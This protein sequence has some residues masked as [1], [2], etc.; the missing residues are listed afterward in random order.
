MHSIE[1]ISLI[2]GIISVIAAVFGYLISQGLKEYRY[3]K[4]RVA[5]FASIISIVSISFSLFY[6]Q[7]K[8]KLPNQTDIQTQLARLDNVQKSLS[9]L[10]KFLSEQ[11]SR[12]KDTETTIQ[13]LEN[14][15][16]TLK[17]IVEADRKTVEAF[18]ILF[19]ERQLKSVWKERIYSFS[20]GIISS[21]LA[22]IIIRLINSKIKSRKP[23]ITAKPGQVKDKPTIYFYDNFETFEGWQDYRKGTISHSNDFSF[24]GNNSLKKHGNNDPNGGYK[25]FPEPISFNFCFSGWI[26][27]PSGKPGGKADRLAVEDENFNGYGFCVAHGSNF[28]QI[29]RR[30]NGKPS[31]TNRGNDFSCPEDQW[32]QFLYYIKSNGILELQI[33]NSDGQSLI[34]LSAQDNKFVTFDRIVIH[35]GQPY[36]VD[37]LKVEAIES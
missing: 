4:W 11:R 32:Y 37:E 8:T 34:S 15:R 35:G 2:L 1:I 10:N 29:E 22:A 25:I 9:D 7:N 13:N 14:E 26:Y 3:K 24:N 33:L 28:L 17:P 5:I 19:E 31:Q 18:A 20:F 36:Y 21:L 6:L 30:E 27:R 12:L 16:A 23:F